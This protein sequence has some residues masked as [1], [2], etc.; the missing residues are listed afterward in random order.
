ME[1][2]SYDGVW[3]NVDNL[4][5]AAKLAPVGSTCFGLYRAEDLID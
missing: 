3:Y 5:T 2:A 1:A 4:G